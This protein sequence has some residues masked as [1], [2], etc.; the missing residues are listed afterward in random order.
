MKNIYSFFTI[1]FP[2]KQKT[3]PMNSFFGKSYALILVEF[4]R[5]KRVNCYE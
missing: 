4:F 3:N 1:V 5:K 2:S